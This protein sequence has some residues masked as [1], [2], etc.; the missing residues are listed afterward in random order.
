MAIVCI[1]A[2][3]RDIVLALK[4]KMFVGQSYDHTSVFK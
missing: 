2:S 3:W 1:T 4:S